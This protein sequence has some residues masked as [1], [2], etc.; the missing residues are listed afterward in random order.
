MIEKEG[1]TTS[2]MLK[3]N[4]VLVVDDEEMMQKMV[5]FILQSLNPEVVVDQAYDGAEAVQRAGGK[6]YDL[7]VLDYSLPWIS[8]NMV[9]RI[10]RNESKNREAK[11]LAISG[12]PTEENIKLMKEAGADDFLAKPFEESA[13]IERVQGLLKESGL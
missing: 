4:R 3:M 11:I 7:I 1:I 12:Y 5:A 13:F 6:P 10:I 2:V 9:G 8:G